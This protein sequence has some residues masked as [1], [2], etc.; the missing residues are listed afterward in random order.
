MWCETEDWS[1]DADSPSQ[2]YI[3]F[4]NV[5]LKRKQLFL[6]VIIFHN[7]AVFLYQISAALLSKIHFFQKHSNILPT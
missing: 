4:K 2:E 7:I 6:I 3:P 5:Y 1:N